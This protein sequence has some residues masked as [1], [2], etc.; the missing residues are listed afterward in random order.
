MKIVCNVNGVINDH[1]VVTDTVL[2][3]CANIF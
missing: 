3:C 1:V 2:N